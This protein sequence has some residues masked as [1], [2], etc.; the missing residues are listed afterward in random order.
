MESHGV[1]VLMGHHAVKLRS[2]ALVKYLVGGCAALGVAMLYTL[3]RASADSLLFTR[4]YPWMLVTGAALS[5]GLLAL[6]SY[7]LWLLRRKLRAGVF[8]AKLTFRLLLAF[9]LMAAVPAALVYAV[10]VRFLAKSIETW[11]DVKVEHALDGGLNLARSTMESLLDDLAV[12]AEAMAITLSDTN[13]KERVGVLNRLREQGSIEEAAL[14]SMRGRVLAF[15]GNERAGLGPDVPP[16]TVL[17]QVR[18]QR[19]YRAV[20]EV[21]EQGLYLRVLVP[22]NVAPGPD[23]VLGLQ[24]LQP[25]PRSLAQD[26]QTVQAVRGSYGEL[27][28]SRQ[29]L[30]RVYALALSLALLL[31]FLSAIA[32]AYLISERLSEP[33]NTLAKSARAVGQGDFSMVSPVQSRDELGM[34]QQTF[35]T[36]TRQLAEAARMVELNQHQLENAKLYLES[37][38]ANLSA[39]VLTFD[40]RFYLRTANV[41]ASEILGVKFADMRG[42]KFEEW[43]AVLAP[44]GPLAREV[45]AEFSRA[46]AK[47]W[48]KQI[49]YARGNEAMVLLVRGARLAAANDND[50]VVVFD[51]ITHLIQ[52]QR[53]A[54]W[55]EVARRLAHEIKNPLTPIQL[56]AERLEHRL[57]DKL[58]PQD[59]AV[60]KRSTE[61]IVAQVAALKGMVNDFSEYARAARMHPESVDL[62][63]LVRQVL[64]LYEP[65]GPNIRAELAEGLPPVRGDIAMLRQV[66]HNLMQNAVDA[67]AGAQ[68][69]TIV[70]KT[71]PASS[72]VRLTVSD[73]GSGFSEALLSRVFEPYVTTK[74]KGTGLGLAIV[75]KIVDEHHGRIQVMNLTPHGA[76]VSIVL[77]LDEAA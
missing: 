23:S 52:A 40:E 18:Q 41:S 26:A 62:N 19:P 47:I 70:V 49:D 74:P 44:I 67:L 33:L 63:A 48:E 17:R 5:L 66:L 45:V 51:D 27:V 37:V 57:S 15:S 32:F 3:S 16:P 60:L 77:P 73:N 31:T 30:R 24:L 69:P 46:G 68:E 71:A 39:G 72:G 43:G 20:E 55:G 36:M 22:V 75:K 76:N 4:Y 11:F 59:A 28:L 6:I 53:A 29:G 13:E 42:T 12:K 54:A 61:T 65:M 21:Q 10:S 58:A 25:V 64:S 34:L 14:L 50:Y 9:A 8:G 38:L 35:N 56:S 1:G 7:Q 2:S